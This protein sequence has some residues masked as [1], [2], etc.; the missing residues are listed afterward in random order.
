M[1]AT[2]TMW[3]HGKRLVLL[4]VIALIGLAGLSGSVAGQ[5]SGEA[6][7]TTMAFDIAEDM[8][9][10]VFDPSNAFEDGMPAYGSAFITQGY[11]YPAGT[12]SEGNGV[13]ADGSPEF[14]DLV[15]GEW[16][17]R[18]WMIGD[19]AHTTTGAMVVT[20]QIYNFGDV[21]GAET[22]VTD[23]FELIDTGIAIERAITGGTG[24]Y[25]NVDGTMQQTFL[26][27][28]ASEGVNLTVEFTLD[29]S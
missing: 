29:N 19:G 7:S 23:G 13:L 14:P 24:Q 1:T 11:I 27:M 5:E 21:L 3:M 10:F 18:G 6:G 9:R 12:L 2:T 22:I 25:A 28:N 17:C 4:A 20:T 26:G 16:T 15:L 8:S